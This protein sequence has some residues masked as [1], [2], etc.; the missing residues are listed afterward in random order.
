MG[1]LFSSP[2]SRVAFTNQTFAHGLNRLLSKITLTDGSYR[3][4]SSASFRSGAPVMLNSSGE[5]VISDGKAC[6]G[7]AMADKMT[8]GSAAVVD[9]E[10]SFDSV[11][12]TAQLTG[13][14]SVT[15]VRI[16]SGTNGS[17][18]IYTGGGTAYSVS[19]SGVVTH[20]GTIPSD[21]TVVYASYRYSL[22]E[23]DYEF[24]GKNFWNSNDEVTIQDGRVAVAL[25]PALIFTTEFET[26][27]G[28]DLL[29]WATTG[30]G[31][32]VYINAS[33]LFT[34]DNAINKCVGH[35]IQ[36]P[37]ADQPFLGFQFTGVTVANT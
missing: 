1:T 22:V 8:L 19:T 14:N 17:G 33:G 6:I 15:E 12:D 28:T 10:I 3:A 32:N 27:L 5:V 26:D 20:V 31:S 2:Q 25:A 18:T 23:A 24:E 7:I 4:A 36:V 11:G 9:E 16:S 35:V 30:L 29:P 37:T 13:Q 21:G 34:T